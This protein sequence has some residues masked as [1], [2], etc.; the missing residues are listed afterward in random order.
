MMLLWAGRKTAGLAYPPIQ[1]DE[2]PD[3]AG[4]QDT[5]MRTDWRPVPV[6]LSIVRV[7]GRH[8][9]DGQSDLITCYM[10]ARRSGADPDNSTS[11]TAGSSSYSYTTQFSGLPEDRW[12]RLYGNI[13]SGQS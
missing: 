4:N 8:R 1:P 13:I 7:F 12:S 11:L 3:P 2:L 10:T 5:L 9:R 6:S